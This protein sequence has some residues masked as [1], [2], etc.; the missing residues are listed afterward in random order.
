MK[1]KILKGESNVIDLSGYRK[2]ERRIPKRQSFAWK[3]LHLA[4]T[5][6]AATA[7]MFTFFCALAFCLVKTVINK[8]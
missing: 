5:V 4:I 7:L 1:G 2:L 8:A 3:L 6:F